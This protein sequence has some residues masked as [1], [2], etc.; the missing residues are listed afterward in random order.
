M[1]TVITLVV[2]IALGVWAYKKWGSRLTSGSGKDSLEALA[3][4]KSLIHE[5][6]EAMA[7]DD[8]TSRNVTVA[9]KAEL[10]AAVAEHVAQGFQLKAISDTTASLEK[11]GSGYKPGKA[12]LYL[13]LCII[14]G[15]IYLLRNPP[16]KKVGEVIL[17]QVE[18]SAE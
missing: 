10:D 3:K 18:A 11:I 16:T 8:I 13:A 12:M 4:G 5:P 17:I 7:R 2:L 15:I 14:P 9:S 1:S 6:G